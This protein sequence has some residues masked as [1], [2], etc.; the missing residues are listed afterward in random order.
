MTFDPSSVRIELVTNF[1]TA[2]NFMEWCRT[3][4]DQLIALDVETD[5]LDWYDG[6]L[7]LVQFGT[8][9]EGWA[10]DALRWRGVI[11]EGLRRIIDRGLAVI[12]HNCAFDQ[13][14]L[15]SSGYPTP[16]WSLSLIHISEPTRPY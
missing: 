9:D 16:L 15:E 3:V 12:M 7:R 6:K 2:Y 8:R 1:D 13:H 5:G 10:L 11:E 4:P 14:A